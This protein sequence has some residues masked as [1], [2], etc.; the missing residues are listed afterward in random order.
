M[1]LFCVRELK[2]QIEELEE[3]L[4]ELRKTL[5][6]VGAAVPGLTWKVAADIEHTESELENLR[7]E[8]KIKA[9]ELASEIM[10]RVA[11]SA[12][13]AVLIG[14]YVKCKTM[15]T[16]ARELGYCLRYTF[17]LHASGVADFDSIDKT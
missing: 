16:L 12:R 15:R 3:R 8:L 11:T 7:S 2:M 5:E 9:A 13:R 4:K 14:R 1:E 10:A 17:K 6:I